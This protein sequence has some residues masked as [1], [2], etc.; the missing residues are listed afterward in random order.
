MTLISFVA[1]A[2]DFKISPKDSIK[3]QG[4][5][6]ANGIEVSRRSW[7]KE[8]TTPVQKSP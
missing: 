5:T 6:E 8:R 7:Q 2:V 1:P 3:E 4:L